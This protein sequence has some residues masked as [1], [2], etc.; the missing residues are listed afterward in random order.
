MPGEVLAQA[1][2]DLSADR[3]SFMR[4]KYAL[5]A[6]AALAHASLTT[7]PGT[8]MLLLLLLLMPAQRCG[9]EDWC[10]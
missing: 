10:V 8:G 3:S 7:K 1:W 6:L 5:K 4:K 2:S 9:G